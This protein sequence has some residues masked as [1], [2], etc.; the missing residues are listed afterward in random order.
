MARVAA[1]ELYRVGAGTAGFTVLDVRA[2]V[3]VARGSLP[4][5]VN[6][7]IL[8]DEERHRVGIAYKEEGQQAAV[9]LG[10]RLTAQTMP[11][12]IAAWREVCSRG[13]TAFSCWRGGMRSQL[14]QS[15]LDD[16][17]VPRVE[18][19]YKALRHHLT[20]GLAPSLARHSVWV[21]AGMTGTGKTDLLEALKGH[22][23]PLVLDLEG[24]AGHRGSSFGSLGPQPAQQTFENELAARILLEPGGTLLVED[25]SRRI[26]SLHLP[27]PLYER[28]K[29]APLLVLEAPWEE[30][31]ARIHRQYIV[32]AVERL[33]PEGALAELGSATGRLRGRLGGALV[34]RLQEILREALAGSGWREAEALEGFIGP[35]L[36]EY[37]DP[38]YHRSIS[39]ME[40][41]VLARGSKEELTNWILT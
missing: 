39:K 29:S 2:P 36:R 11:K 20:A 38:L 3:E 35:L 6:V 40:R 21:L 26:G 31:V 15:F 25:E 41:S 27:A 13:P 28:M 37:Y 4:G 8:E 30:R 33:G 24:M 7:P 10:H 34:E 17:R 19:G 14:A 23:A 16:R 22:P 32:E 5:S 9:E 18:G 12:R 1:A